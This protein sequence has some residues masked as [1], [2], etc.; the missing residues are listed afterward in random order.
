MKNYFSLLSILIALVVIALKIELDLATYHAFQDAAT[1]QNTAHPAMVVGG[2][3]FLPISLVVVSLVLAVF[4][5]EKNNK[6]RILAITINI[7]TIF[8]LMVPIGMFLVKPM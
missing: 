8:Y 4:G 5:L 6:Y 3:T 7:I 1:T 2:L